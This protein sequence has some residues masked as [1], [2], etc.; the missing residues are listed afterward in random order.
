MEE[1]RA[2]AAPEIYSTVALAQ[3]ATEAGSV[4]IYFLLSGELI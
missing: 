1:L 3:K 2:C 4:F